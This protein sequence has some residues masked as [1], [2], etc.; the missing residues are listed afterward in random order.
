MSPRELAWC[1]RNE[2]KPTF[3]R[4]DGRAGY[5]ELLGHKHYYLFP[6]LSD[7]I[8]RMVDLLEWAMIKEDLGDSFGRCVNWQPGQ[9]PFHRYQWDEWYVNGSEFTSGLKAHLEIHRPRNVYHV[10]HFGR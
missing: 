10:S 1:R 3:Q 8:F 2:V 7:G 9:R 6:T 4:N 5:L